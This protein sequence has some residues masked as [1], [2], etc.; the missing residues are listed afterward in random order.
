MKEYVEFVS[1]AAETT[2]GE[3]LPD[4]RIVNIYRKD[5]TIHKYDRAFDLKT[6]ELYPEGEFPLGSVR[7]NDLHT[8]EVHC[9]KEARYYEE[10]YVDEVTVG[11]RLV[12]KIQ[13]FFEQEG[14]KVKKEAIEHCLHSWELDMKSGYRDE[15]GGYHLFMPCC[16]NPLAI[17]LSTLHPACADWQETYQC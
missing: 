15:E 1:S 13:K 8:T 9:Y 14:Y 16:H 11:P 6:G 12:K 17:T 3:Q 7:L 4:G 5:G 2:R 10:K